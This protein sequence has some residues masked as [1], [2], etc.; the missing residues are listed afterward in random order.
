LGGAHIFNL[1]HGIM[2]QTDPNH[3]QHLI[4]V[5]KDFDRKRAKNV[6]GC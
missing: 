4:D 5:V 1:G 2:R 6:L 3:A